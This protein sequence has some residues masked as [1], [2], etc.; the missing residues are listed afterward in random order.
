MSQQPPWNYSDPYMPPHVQPQVPEQ[1]QR[2]AAVTP[3]RRR[4]PYPSHLVRFPAE[5][6]GMGG[7]R[8]S[9]GPSF[10]R[11]VYLGTHPVALLMSI[12]LFMIMAEVIVGWGA[13]VTAIWLAWV[14]V[15][16]LVWLFRVTIS[17]M[18]SGHGRL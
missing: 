16:T 11:M 17:A 1:W 3:A 7:R 4:P 15:V 9:R 5:L 8:R 14:A 12:F 10:W 6:L 2:K 18:M 13:V